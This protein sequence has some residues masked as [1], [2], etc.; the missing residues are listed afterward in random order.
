[1]PQ[2]STKQST[3]RNI[4]NRMDLASP[5]GQLQAGSARLIVNMLNGIRIPGLRRYGHD[6]PSRAFRN[7][8]LHDQLLGAVRDQSYSP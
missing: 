5:D 7:Q 4:P 8:D 2:E 6:D 1:M 3:I